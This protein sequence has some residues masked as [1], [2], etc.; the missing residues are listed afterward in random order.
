MTDSQDDLIWLEGNNSDVVQWRQAQQLATETLLAGIEAR[1]PLQQ[2]FTQLAQIERVYLP[3]VKAGVFFW[4]ADDAARELLRI[5]CRT[6]QDGLVRVL[7]DPNSLVAQQQRVGKVMDIFP[8]DDGTLLAVTL[9][10]DENSQFSINLLDVSRGQWL[11]ECLSGDYYPLAKVWPGKSQLV[12]A[13][14]HSGFYYSRKASTAAGSQQLYFHQVGQAFADDVLLFAQPPEDAA[15]IY[16][17]LS[18]GG[19]FLAL[20]RQ[21]QGGEQAKTSVYL[22]DL[23]ND[24]GFKP[25]LQD[26]AAIIDVALTEQQ[27]FVLTNHQAPNWQVLNVSLKHNPKYGL[28]VCIETT[29]QT[30]RNWLVTANYILLERLEHCGSLLQLF[31]LS[32]HYLGDIALPAVGC[33]DGLTQGESPDQVIYR[34]SSFMIAPTI[35]TVNLVTYQSTNWHQSQHQPQLKSSLLSADDYQ[36]KQSHFVADDNVRVPVTLISRK[37]GI[38]TGD[39]PTIVKAY[40]GFGL[41]LLP[42]F[43]AGI[44]PFLAEG[45]LY[46]IA[47][48]RGG[49]ELGQQWH[50]A[51]IKEKRLRAFNDLNQTAMWLIEQGYT[52]AQRL[53]CFGWSNGGL[54][55]N[56]AAILRP[57]LW[58]LVI[59]GSPVT[60]LLRF[61]LNHHGK[62]WRSDYGDPDNA[63][64]QWYL[65]QLSPCHR[66]P[67]QIAAPAVMI[68]VPEQDDRVAPWHGYKLITRWQAANSGNNPTLLFSEANA[69]HKGSLSTTAT[70]KRQ[71]AIWSLV[72]DQLGVGS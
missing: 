13:A 9:S 35:Y 54:T 72:F 58:Q 59:A 39:Q 71:L 29:S 30:V 33:I 46:V 40:G 57:D 18:P 26:V 32:G 56:A 2:Q 65:R 10:S 66:M 48:I 6:G 1:Q 15:M 61:H 45:G 67:K 64:H 19:R 63:D 60:D 28:K 20:I 50:H 23:S 3:V 51:A 44:V 8:S 38:K 27:L 42:Q 43:D 49:G 36:I 69:G 70:V 55:V 53:G 11:P 25:L 68:Y 21:D 31:D 16:P 47:H 52:R 37:A 14:D 5:C 4:L 62:Q 22:K 17:R 41:S 12:W 24:G 34:F 7:W